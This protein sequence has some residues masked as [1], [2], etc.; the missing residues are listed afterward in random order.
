[1]KV[2]ITSSAMSVPEKVIKNSYFESYLDTSDEWI[3]ERT[4]IKERRFAPKGTPS[5]YYGAESAKKVIAKRGI[6]PKDIQGIIF[7]TVTPDMLFPSSAF[8]VQKN[9][10]APNNI[11]GYDLIAACSGYVYALYTAYSLIKSGN[12]E[13]ILVVGADIMSTIA[14]MEDRGTCVLFGDGGGS[15]IVEKISD[16]DDTGFIDFEVGCDGT[17]GDYLY[18]PAGGS[19]NPPSHETI[20]K[21]MHY[22]KMSGRDVYKWAVR[23]MTQVAE[24]LLKRNGFKGNDLDLLVPHQAN[25]RIIE[26]IMDRLE[27]PKE[28]VVIN[29]DRYGNTTN[30]SIPIC[31][32][33]AE[34]DGRLTRGKL[35][36]IVT[37]GGGFTWGGILLRWTGLPV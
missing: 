30:A 2:G 32:S 17:G 19:L 6:S 27:L 24:T 12:F 16:N 11:L 9:I 4:G 18:M 14:D 3:T 37:F 10:G 23:N 29:I 7:A 13:K 1:M 26:A 21:R 28:K 35:V 25:I 36:C 20:D 34:D 22:I 5:S 31:L 8:L 15:V 33:E